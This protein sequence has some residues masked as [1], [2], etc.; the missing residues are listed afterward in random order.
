VD[1][2]QVGDVSLAAVLTALCKAGK[3]VLLPWGSAQRYD[4]VI[5]DKGTFYRVQVKTGRLARDGTAVIFRTANYVK[6]RFKH[7]QGEIELFGV[8]CPETERVYL[9]PVE[10]TRKMVCTLRLVPAKNGQ[11]LRVHMADDYLLTMG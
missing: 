9:V 6:G 1:T 7:Y 11:K 8:Y 4:L 3:V 5:D 2:N 10:H